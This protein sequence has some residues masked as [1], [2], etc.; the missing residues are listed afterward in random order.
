MIKLE[1]EFASLAEA[2]SALVALAAAGGYPLVKTQYVPSVERDG[3]PNR[4]VEIKSA[5]DEPHADDTPAEAEAKEKRKRRTKAEM[6]AYRLQQ[7]LAPGSEN[8]LNRAAADFTTEAAAHGR[9][10][11]AEL[12]V[13]S[14]TVS[15]APA[16]VSFIASGEVIDTPAIEKLPAGGDDI[17]DIYAA[18]AVRIYADALAKY[19]EGNPEKDEAA[20][21][22]A[23]LHRVV[24]VVGMD[25]VQAFMKEN[26]FRKVSD[27]PEADRQRFFEAVNAKAGVK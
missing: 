15:G 19:L 8:A 3:E 5:D 27:I 13:A 16:S 10:D 17:S 26:G 7:K 11:A 4:S 1:L 24:D 2:S 21:L 25:G 18:S 23:Q 14:A 9:P 20:F 22:R 12:A 6:E